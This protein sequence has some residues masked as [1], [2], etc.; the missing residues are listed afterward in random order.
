MPTEKI[1]FLKQHKFGI[2]FS[3]AHMFKKLAAQNE[4][5]SKC[6]T[7]TSYLN[8]VGAENMYFSINRFGAPLWK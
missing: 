1:K 3:P 4:Y 2:T 5:L 7:P 6:G 8:V